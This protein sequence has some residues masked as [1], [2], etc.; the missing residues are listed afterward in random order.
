MKHARITNWMGLTITVI[1]NQRPDDHQQ[2]VYGVG[3]DEFLMQTAYS[4]TVDSTFSH[5]L[6]I[7]RTVLT[8]AASPNSCNF[9]PN[10]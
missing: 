10:Q 4:T 6:S 5:G 9:C 7:R 8:P 3:L 1:S 2:R